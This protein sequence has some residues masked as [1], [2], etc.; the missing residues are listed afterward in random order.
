M[1]SVLSIWNFVPYDKQKYKY[2]CSFCFFF[3]QGQLEQRK[4]ASK[5]AKITYIRTNIWNKS[6]IQS[7]LFHPGNLESSSVKTPPADKDIYAEID[8]S[9]KRKPQNTDVVSMHS[10][11]LYES[12]G[13]IFPPPIVP[14][15]N[16]QHND[17]AGE[18]NVDPGVTSVEN[19]L[20]GTQPDLPN[21]AQLNDLSPVEAENANGMKAGKGKRERTPPDE[22]HYGSYQHKSTGWSS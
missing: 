15:F 21:G 9:R 10:N 1:K 4:N 17:A 14:L 8:K 11:D 18:G 16:P 20:Y 3:L 22:P 19:E 13:S 6:E 5:V 2:V 7:F 12:S